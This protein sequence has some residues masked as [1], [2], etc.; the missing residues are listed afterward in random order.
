MIT[1]YNLKACGDILVIVLAP[2]AD[3]QQVTT[4]GQVTRIQDRGTKK[5]T[6]FNIVGLGKQLNITLQNGRIFLNKDQITIVNNV[7]REAGFNDVLVAEASKLV[8]GRV[9]SITAHPDSDHLSVTSTAVSDEKV[10]QIV[11]GSPNMREGIKVVVAQPGTMMPS[12]ALIW[13]GALRG[14]PSSGMIVSGRE[15]Q[16]DGAPDKPGALILPESFGEIGEPFNFDKAKSLYKD[17]LV[18]TEY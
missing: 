14:V 18:D 9:K 12:G 15:L 13:D 1:T 16:L 11:S 17:G 7:I 10:L 6:G 8:I 4:N 3:K 5:T 2:N